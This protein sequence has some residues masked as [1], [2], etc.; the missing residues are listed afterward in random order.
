MAGKRY[1]PRLSA[2]NIP[3]YLNHK[4]DAIL[5]FDI[6]EKSPY[7][8]Y[9]YLCF[10]CGVG[11][12]PHNK[13]KKLVWDG[14][15]YGLHTVVKMLNIWFRLQEQNKDNQLFSTSKK[16]GKPQHPPSQTSF[17]TLLCSYEANHLLHTQNMGI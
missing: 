5:V 7:I 9:R 8:Y 6:S 12:S 10:E 3:I 17:F 16:I 11:G 2:K 13:L 14:A 4:P 15:C 1:N